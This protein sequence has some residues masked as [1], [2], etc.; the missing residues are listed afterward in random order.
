MKKSFKFTA[1]VLSLLTVVM[2]VSQVSAGGH[3]KKPT[4]G[5]T[6]HSSKRSGYKKTKKERVE[7]TELLAA[8]EKPSVSVTPPEKT[9]P[10]MSPQSRPVSKFSLPVE[11]MGLTEGALQFCIEFAQCNQYEPI[12]FN[13]PGGAYVSTRTMSANF[14]ELSETIQRLICLFK[15]S[16]KDP[17][18]LN[19]R[20]YAF[21][22]K[23]WMEKACHQAESDGYEGGKRIIM[24]D[25][26]MDIINL[27]EF[28]CVKDPSSS[29]LEEGTC[30]SQL[31]IGYKN[32]VLTAEL[33]NEGEVVYHVEI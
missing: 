22:V 8:S 14:S 23:N 19:V 24:F 32:D 1:L 28:T 13:V 26:V 11:P 27:I 6:S 7:K 15:K 33:L 17:H 25:A 21:F 31:R 3:K 20:C 29:Q 16:E 2:P 5:K 30:F 10:L 9:L 18:K 12:V 4:S